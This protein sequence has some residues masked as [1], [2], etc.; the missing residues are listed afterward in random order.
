M[1]IVIH[2]I[3]LPIHLVWFPQLS[4]SHVPTVRHSNTYLAIPTGTR[5]KMTSLALS[6]LS[7]K[8][9][10][11]RPFLQTLN[12]SARHLNLLEYQSKK[13]LAE[14]G[15]A[16]QAFRVLEGK[17]D[18]SVLKDFSK[19]RTYLP[20]IDCTDWS[21]LVMLSHLRRCLSFA[22]R[23]KRVCRQSTNSRWRPG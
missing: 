15:V 18:E 9:L 20:C 22:R 3:S 10:A 8:L 6:K 16:I 23:C 11:R 13:L 12:L 7:A 19:Y 4:T 21:T 5:A 2:L 14:S 17:K 1:K